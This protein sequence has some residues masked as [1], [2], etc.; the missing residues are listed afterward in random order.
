MLAEALG[1]PAL[2]LDRCIEQRAGCSVASFWAEHG[3]MAFRALEEKELT[4]RL[5]A[6]EPHV[7][8]LGGGTLLSKPLRHRLLAEHKILGLHAP[9]TTLISRIGDAAD[10]PLLQ[11]DSLA[12]LEAMLEARGEAYAEVHARIGTDGMLEQVVPRLLAAAEAADMMMPLGSRSHPIQLSDGGLEHQLAAWS[13]QA[14][15]RI[16][17]WLVDEGAYSAHA[18][19]FDALAARSG[20]ALHRVAGGERNKT[21]SS[22]QHLW[23]VFAS[24]KID[25]SQHVAI[26]GGGVVSD[27]CAFAASTWHR[28]TPHLIVPTTLL[29]MADA[30]VGGK[31][32]IDTESG[33]NLVGTTWQPRAVFVDTS[34]L[35]SVPADAWR[36][37]QA[38]LAKVAAL[39]DASLFSALRSDVVPG[40]RELRRALRV[41]VDLVSADEHDQR[42][43]ALLNF[44]HTV[45]HA[46]EVSSGYAL[47]HGVAVAEGMRLET[48][49][50][51]RLGLSHPSALE[52]LAT[53]LGR[54]GLGR[55]EWPG[56]SG[57]FTDAILADKKMAAGSLRLTGLSALGHASLVHVPAMTFV[58]AL[59]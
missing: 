20:A 2:D 4:L 56:G 48:E 26:A 17:L 41:K 5:A 12:R 25:R 39:R 43:R 21:L 54:L 18:H 36:A 6:D 30:S 10:R 55:A 53:E 13:K 58:D 40:A 3:E 51:V 35:R 27:L 15:A 8:A 1:A 19:R 52:A 37:D 11:G 14:N 22:V 34:F 9:L 46:L 29:G 33:K 24:A 31:T 47:R 16:G 57:G 23:T 59:R 42:E 44:G 32:A 38:E 7:I 50:L 49:A 45:G 28:G